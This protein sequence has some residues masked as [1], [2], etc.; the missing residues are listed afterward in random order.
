MRRAV[1]IIA[2]VSLCLVQNLTG[3]TSWTV[4]SYFITHK[5]PVSQRKSQSTGSSPSTTM[6]LQ[7]RHQHSKSV[8]S[9]TSSSLKTESSVALD[10]TR[11]GSGDGGE[12]RRRQRQISVAAILASCF[13]NLLGFTMASPITP[14]L[15]LGYVGGTFVLA[16]TVKTESVGNGQFVGSSEEF[17]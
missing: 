10:A 7:H 15:S 1:I 5:A 13:L 2:L 4:S 11:E 17:D 8:S 16:S 3:V 12:R 9:Q 14:A 6:S